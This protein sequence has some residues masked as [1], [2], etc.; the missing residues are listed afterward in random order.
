MEL[1]RRLRDSAFWALASETRLARMAAY[2]DCEI[3]CQYLVLDM[4]EFYIEEKTYSLI[5]DLLGLAALQGDSVALVLQALGSD[6]A[7]D[8]GGL[9]VR[10]LA[11]TL[12]LDLTSNDVLADLYVLRN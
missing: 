11:L 10:L 4:G 9:G 3:V 7:L 1:A 2:S 12:G 5:L 6:Q 8:L